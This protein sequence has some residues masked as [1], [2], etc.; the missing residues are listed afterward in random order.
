MILDFPGN[1]LYLLLNNATWTGLSAFDAT[2][3]LASDL[4]GSGRDDIVVD[5][6]PA[7]GLYVYRNGTAW[8]QLHPLSPAHVAAGD[9]DGNGRADLVVDFGAPNGAEVIY[10]TMQSMIAGEES[11]ERGLARIEES[12]Q[13]FLD[14][15][16]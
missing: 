11:L 10:P 8:S 15:L 5:F 6:G 2:A 16:Q 14:S 13:A 12:R 3:V 9:V 1:G 7:Y 4:D